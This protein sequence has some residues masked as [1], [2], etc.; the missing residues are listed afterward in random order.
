M[1]AACQGEWAT[2]TKQ[3]LLRVERFLDGIHRDWGSAVLWQA[4]PN[5]RSRVRPEP[6]VFSPG[7]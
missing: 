3:N 7:I 6:R 2:D 5:S 4:S 1:I